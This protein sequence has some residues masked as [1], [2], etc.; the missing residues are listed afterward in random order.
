LFQ[1]KIWVW[2]CCVQN[3]YIDDCIM[4]NVLESNNNNKV[5][6]TAIFAF[7][8]VIRRLDVQ[9][10]HGFIGYIK[11]CFKFYILV[12]N[13]SFLFLKSNIY[14]NWWPWFSCFRKILSSNYWYYFLLFSVVVRILETVG[15]SWICWVQINHSKGMLQDLNFI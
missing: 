15:Y 7:K 14:S 12:I 4:F 1:L 11:K 13:W 10:N 3:V 9:Q 2:C 8:E 6:M 5:R